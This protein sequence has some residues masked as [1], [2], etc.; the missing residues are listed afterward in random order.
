MKTTLIILACIISI[1]AVIL[2]VLAEFFYEVV[3]NMKVVKKYAKKFNMHDDTL[4]NL[5]R[6]NQLYSDSMKWFVKLKL[7][8]TVIKNNECKDVH[9]YII[10]NKNNLKK[11]A[12]CVH[13]YMGTPSIQAPYAKHFY[14][15]GYSVVCPSLRAH[16]EDKNRYCSMGWHDKDV[17]T[18]WINYLVNKYPGC[19]IVLHGISMGATT[20]ML[21][22]GEKLP[23]NVKCAVSD[24]GFSSC[25][26]QF[27][28]VMKNRM[29]IPV[30]PFFQ[31]G[32]IISVVRGNL[33]FKTC[34]AIEAV[35]KS[36]TPTL[37]I[38]GTADDF[39]PYSMI[40]DVW[41]ACSAEKERLDVA[42]APHAVSLA[43]DSDLYFSTMD[44][45]IE[46]YST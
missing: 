31:L 18:T 1:A 43:Y 33:N 19:E 17:V 3:L 20:V 5:F 30:F 23:S 14:D 34:S 4:I 24:C 16:G 41:E 37:F 36:V 35:A 7:Q 8:D 28:H 12:I 42:D 22:T 39:V 15:T 10:E 25:K 27:I 38:H 44:S 40:E 13:G 6:N 21:T 11:W 32:N 46:K 2:L 26:K 45:F 29:K 9:G